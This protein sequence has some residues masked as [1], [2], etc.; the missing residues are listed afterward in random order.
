MYDERKKKKGLA[1][2]CVFVGVCAIVSSE[3]KHTDIRSVG[4]MT[5]QGDDVPGSRWHFVEQLATN[6]VNK[7]PEALAVFDI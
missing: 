1:G 4:K 7:I 2:N 3:Y 5:F 6:F